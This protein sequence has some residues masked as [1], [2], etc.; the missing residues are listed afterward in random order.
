MDIVVISK[1]ETIVFDNIEINSKEIE[2]T[3]KISE[4][5]EVKTCRRLT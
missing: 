2:D 1:I 3:L 5:K 4:E